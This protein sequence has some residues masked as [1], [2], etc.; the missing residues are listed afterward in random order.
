MS[1]LVTVHYDPSQVSPTEIAEAIDTAVA[2]IASAMETR[3][4]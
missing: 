4:G 3:E 1:K 2:D